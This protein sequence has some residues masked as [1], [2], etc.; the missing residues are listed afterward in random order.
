MLSLIESTYYRDFVLYESNRELLVG[1][2]HKL[3][4]IDY[5]RLMSAKYSKSLENDYD[6]IIE[7]LSG[8]CIIVRR[9]LK[10]KI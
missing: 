7:M 3:T 9:N 5:D 4:N 6:I 8:E 10:N 2:L 1:F